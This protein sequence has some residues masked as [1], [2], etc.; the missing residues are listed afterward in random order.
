MS[1]YRNPITVFPLVPSGMLRCAVV[2]EGAKFRIAS[3][4]LPIPSV[5]HFVLVFQA[6]TSSCAPRCVSSRLEATEALEDESA[7][8]GLVSGGPNSPGRRPHVYDH[9]ALAPCHSAS[10]RYSF[11]GVMK[12]PAISRPNLGGAGGACRAFFA[13]HSIPAQV[14]LLTPHSASTRGNGCSTWRAR[15]CISARS[16]MPESRPDKTSDSTH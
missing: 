10:P 9:C 3:L 1:T 14:P 8:T 12:S 15:R 16:R 2:G 6:S 13:L 7:K 11:F 5:S 4:G